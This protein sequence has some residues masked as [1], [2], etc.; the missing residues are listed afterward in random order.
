MKRIFT[1]LSVVLVMSS[2][3]AHAADLPRSAS[4][5]GTKIYVI[6]P[7]NGETVAETFTVRFGLQV[8]GVAPAGADVNNTGHHHLLIDGKQL[9]A[10]NKPMGDEV[11]HFGGGQTEKTLT[12]PK[13]QHT[14]QLILGNHLHIPH[15]PPVVSDIITIMV[16]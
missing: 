14:L 9:P 2:V 16:K 8:M 7:A 3:M 13:G 11:M 10:G 4:P 6:S 15:D 5:E 12:L 1:I